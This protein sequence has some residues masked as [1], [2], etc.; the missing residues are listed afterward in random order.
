MNCLWIFLLLFGCG[1]N[2]GCVNNRCACENARDN[3]CDNACDCGND[4]DFGRN[5]DRNRNDGCGCDRD[6]DD[7][8]WDRRRDRDRGRDRDRDDYGSSSRYPNISRSET[9][10]CE[11][12]EQ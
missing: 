6:D 5:D 2:R 10:G 4:N 3:V 1:S 12:S 7:R 9:C 11:K 8:N